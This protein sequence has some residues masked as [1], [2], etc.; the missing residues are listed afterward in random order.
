MPYYIANKDFPKFRSEKRLYG[1]KLLEQSGLFGDLNSCK[2]IKTAI[3]FGSFARGDWSNSSDIDLFIYGDDA[4]FHKGLY[5]T[6]LHRDLHVFAYK[7]KKI[8]K[9]NLDRTVIPNITKGFYIT[10]SIE[11]FKVSIHA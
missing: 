4:E 3:L 8:L 1:L 2:D 5:E 7:N 9:K 11:P 10:N 6:K